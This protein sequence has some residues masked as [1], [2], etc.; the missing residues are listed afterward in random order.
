MSLKEDLDE[1]SKEI[2]LKEKEERKKF[3]QEKFGKLEKISSI[4]SEQKN[5]NKKRN[6]EEIEN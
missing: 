6:R 5:I 4:S 3:L 2:K 1:D